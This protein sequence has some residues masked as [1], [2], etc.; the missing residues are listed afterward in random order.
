MQKI[1]RFGLMLLNLEIL[2]VKVASV[3]SIK[4]SMC[5]E[6]VAVKSLIKDQKM[7]QATVF[8]QL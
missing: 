7:G 5:G 3:K 2:L 1:G 8:S 4:V 6:N